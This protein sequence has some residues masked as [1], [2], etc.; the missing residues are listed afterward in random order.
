VKRQPLP[1]YLMKEFHRLRNE[2]HMHQEA[3]INAL[4]QAQV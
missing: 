4:I 3:A 2:E 1:E